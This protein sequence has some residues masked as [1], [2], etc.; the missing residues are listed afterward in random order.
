[1]SSDAAT[2]TATNSDTQTTATT[3]TES[4]STDH[5]TVETR[6]DASAHAEDAPA[7]EP[8]PAVWPPADETAWHKAAREAVEWALER[9]RADGSVLIV[10]SHG[11]DQ[12]PGREVEVHLSGTTSLIDHCEGLFAFAWDLVVPFGD[13]GRLHAPDRSMVADAV[14]YWIDA[15]PIQ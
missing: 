15:H 3:N 1:M 13:E 7:A 4:T 10:P 9:S 6:A 12:E 11:P 14:H 8:E 2:E 5:T